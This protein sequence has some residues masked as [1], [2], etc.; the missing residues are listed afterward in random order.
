MMSPVKLSW[1]CF[2]FR[3]VCVNVCTFIINCFYFFIV[4]AWFSETLYKEKWF[5]LLHGNLPG[6]SLSLVNFVFAVFLSWF[7]IVFCHIYVPGLWINQIKSKSN[8]TM[9]TEFWL[10]LEL[11]F[12]QFLR[13]WS[14]KFLEI[15]DFGV[16]VG[17]WELKCWNKGLENGQGV[18]KWGLQGPTY[19]YPIFQGV[20]SPG[21]NIHLRKSPIHFAL[22]NNLPKH[23]K[24]NK[25]V[26]AWEKH[27]INL[28]LNKRDSTK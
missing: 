19:P 28:T 11:N 3:P 15:C 18:W 9:C 8:Q 1:I 24:S 10:N 2:R 12:L 13:V 27:K 25:S 20:S 7:V 23:S 4:S 21:K 14:L 16:K 6:T 17:S 22:V 26:K 5:S